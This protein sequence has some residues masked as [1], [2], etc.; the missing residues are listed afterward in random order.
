VILALSLENSD[1]TGSQ[2]AF[3]RACLLLL[4]L[5]LVEGEGE[6]EEEETQTQRRHRLT[7]F[8]DKKHT[9]T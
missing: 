2:S 7:R 5:P 6:R 1:V 3:G 4:L 9:C 8:T